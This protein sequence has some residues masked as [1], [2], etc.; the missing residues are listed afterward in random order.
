MSNLM[1]LPGDEQ[2]YEQE[3]Y[4]LIVNASLALSSLRQLLNNPSV[5]LSLAERE[6]CER[7]ATALGE[8]LSEVPEVPEVPEPEPCGAWCG[9]EVPF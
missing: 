6:L 8:C 9:N 1:E 3:Y 2:E 5:D 7:N 4:A